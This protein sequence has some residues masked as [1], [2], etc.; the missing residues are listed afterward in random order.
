[1]LQMVV[2][3]FLGAG[4]VAL[5]LA[6]LMMQERLRLIEAPPT[7]SN[8]PSTPSPDDGA[9]SSTTR[10][11]VLPLGSHKLRLNVQTQRCTGSFELVGFLC[12]SRCR[13]PCETC[14]TEL[15][16]RMSLLYG[17]SPSST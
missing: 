15:S 13:Q 3:T 2:N 14:L 7:G 5:T 10:R 12:D 6:L 9:S 4:V 1:M 16:M 17:V 8:P 11:H